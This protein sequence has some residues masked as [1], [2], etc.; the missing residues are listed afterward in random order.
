MVERCRSFCFSFL[1]SGLP[2]GS[3]WSTPPKGASMAIAAATDAGE[4]FVV[5]VH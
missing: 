4:E 5:G 1:P 2:D 3:S